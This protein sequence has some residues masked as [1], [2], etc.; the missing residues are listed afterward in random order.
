MFAIYNALCMLRD[1]TLTLFVFN[2]GLLIYADKSWAALLLL[3][4]AFSIYFNKVKYS[5]LLD[6]E[7]SYL[8]ARLSQ[9]LTILFGLFSVAAIFTQLEAKIRFLFTQPYR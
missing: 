4:L 1:L 9:I 6:K 5:H 7:L 3:A 2:A 8:G